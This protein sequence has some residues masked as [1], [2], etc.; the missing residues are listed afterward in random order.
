MNP[1]LTVANVKLLNMAF[2]ALRALASPSFLKPHTTLLKLPEFNHLPI[3]LMHILLSGPL[4]MILPLLGNLPSVLGIKSSLRLPQ[5]NTS[6]WDF[7][8]PHMK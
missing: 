3:H 7:L 6:A 2:E 1:H 8:V 4:Y 5:A